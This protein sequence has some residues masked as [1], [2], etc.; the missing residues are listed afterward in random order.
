[1]HFVQLI[2]PVKSEST[3][4]AE[5]QMTTQVEHKTSQVPTYPDSDDLQC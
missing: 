5:V 4:F 2:T 3:T 1:M